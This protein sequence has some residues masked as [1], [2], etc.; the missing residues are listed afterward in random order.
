[1]N[2]QNMNKI[3]KI[4]K[5]SLRGA[6][7]LACAVPLS[8]QVVDEADD[9]LG[10]DD[11]YTLSPFEVMPQADDAYTATD[12]LGGT[13]VR[14]DLRDLSTPL[15][16]ITSQM[17]SDTGATGNEGLLTYTTSTEVGGLYGNWGGMGNTQGI[18]DRA[19]LL[20]PDNTTRV[21]GLD[22]ADNTR[23]YFL[24]DIPWDSYNIDRVEIQRGPNS[25]LF[26]VGS[27]AG[28]IN[29]ATVTAKMN[30][31]SG[32]LEHTYSKFGSN[33]IVADYN[34]ELID[35]VLAVRVTGLWNH[36]KYRQKPAFNNDERIFAT[37]TFQKQLLPSEWADK[38]TAR[39]S[40]EKA[41]V[42]SNNPRYMPP[43][44]AISSWFEDKAGD[45][46][47]D[48]IGLGQELFDPLLY[49]NVG[50]G[51]AQSGNIYTDA[52]VKDPR[53]VPYTDVFNAG[54]L[55]NGGLGFWY[56]NG[57]DDP[58]FVSKQSLGD[59]S[60]TINGE[61]VVDGSGFHS[62][63]IPFGSL[64]RSGGL[65]EYAKGLNWIDTQY[66][67]LSSLEARF[68][69]ASKGYYKDQSLTDASV[70]DFYNQLIDGDNKREH[71][72]WDAAN[73]S[74]SQTFFGGRLGFEFVYDTQDYSEWR[75]GVTLNNPYIAID[76]NKNLASQL[77]SY[78]ERVDSGR[79]DGDGNPIMVIDST[80]YSVPGFTPTAEQPY[81]NAMAGSAFLSGSFAANSRRDMER[82]TFRW[83]GYAELRGSDFF[84][85]DSLLARLI[86]THNFTGLL[87]NEER[88][89]TTTVWQPSAVEYSWADENANNHADT[90][91]DQ[92]TRGITPIIY[93]SGPLMGT[94]SASGL[95][96]GP[97]N[98]YYTPSGSYTVDYF[99]ATW[100]RPL[101]PE[102][103]DYVDPSATTYLSTLGTYLPESE[104]PANYVGRTTAT[105]DILNAQNGDLAK[106]T[107]SYGIRETKV[108]SEGLVWQGK[109]L[110]GLIVPTYGWRR[111]VMKT[112]T[113]KAEEDATG[114]VDTTPQDTTLYL[115]NEGQTR[116]WGMV[117]HMPDNWLDGVSFIDGVSA[118]YNEGSNSRVEARYNFDGEPLENATADST[119]YG[120]VLSMFDET[121]SIKLGKF[122]TKVKNANLAGGT[123]MLGN[124]MYYLYNLEAWGTMD[125]IN[126]LYGIGHA[127]PNGNDASW[128]WAM[129]DDG[130]WGKMAYQE[131]DSDGDNVPDTYSEYTPGEE[132]WENHPSTIAQKAAIDSWI[133]GM[134]QTFFDNYDIPINVADLQAAYQ[135]FLDTGDISQVVAV[136]EAA[137]IG[138]GV[139]TS[140]LSSQ[141]NGEINGIT[142]NGTIDN[143]SEGY[144][145]EVN[146][147]PVPNW[148]IQLNASKIDAY[149]E[150]IG[151]PMLE[152]IEKQ[153]ERMQSPA[154]DI[155]LWWGG[156]N[157]I[158]T[159]YSDN[160][161]SALDFQKESIGAQV[162]E[163]RPYSASLITNY[164]FQESV[165][166]GFNIG[167]GVRW[168]DSQILG[169]G[170][171]DDS[172]EPE[173]DVNK[174]IKGETE[175]HF[176]FWA[177]YEKA[178]SDKIDWR[179]QLNVRNVGESVGL[180]P[181]A[182]NPDGK[183][184]YQRI[185]EGMTWSISNTFSF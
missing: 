68:P 34:V 53:Y 133:N 102:D 80:N 79:V 96:L 98:T 143:T 115:T 7:F 88:K 137:G 8:A 134:D 63:A 46:V 152:F 16:A 90:K 39:L 129:I 31:N 168:Q 138:P 35:D 148:N 38:F 176:D 74:L 81:A 162:P 24:S 107:S 72:E 153:W 6:L 52:I 103:P 172:D 111:D 180:T 19:A 160:I 182:V 84:D 142:P 104:N 66:N 15:S 9:E 121:L 149:R 92:S 118:Y 151:Q 185:T 174:P 163:L 36:A 40:Y 175:T 99:D 117:A 126:Y 87:S 47:N 48:P 119:D 29:T 132:Y 18:S 14:T 124:N 135:H 108:D 22:A 140:G 64:L 136:G 57:S 184:A 45:G 113:Y 83:T 32:K 179:I 49:R 112:Y 25:I 42:I 116:S 145:L 10:D 131:Y 144:E 67:G 23:N 183:V 170:L 51:L 30:G 157:P 93:L 13:R 110:D 120:I 91:V 94:S 164:A 75:T 127:L 100:N 37:A 159:Y 165:L 171:K 86:G 141:N 177:G 82:D 76:M 147:R 59:I 3:P 123:N 106:L 166:K 78:G 114:V 1:M 17:L 130:Q 146:Y 62:D 85:D 122:K 4:V 169:F 20:R 167:G 89:E 158:E 12:T 156:D 73:L 11:I 50:G 60:G 150:N 44:D 155:R 33:R 109:L 21:R 128:N 43:T 101:D 139:G 69:G 178:I 161:I 27:P 70:F 181:I 55:A 71:K 125:A 97:I 54:S 58:L 28:I 41:K 95:N 77:P 65:N 105:V 26:G 5:R 154:G 61:G 173:L 56:N 2:K